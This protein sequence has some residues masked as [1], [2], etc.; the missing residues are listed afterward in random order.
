MVVCEI[1]QQKGEQEVNII[2]KQSNRFGTGHFTLCDLRNIAARLINRN[3]SKSFQPVSSALIQVITVRRDTNGGRADKI[4]LFLSSD[5]AERR[6]KRRPGCR[7][8]H[9]C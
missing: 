4:A 8:G 5:K 9:N 3:E 6:A 7:S 2:S 1:K